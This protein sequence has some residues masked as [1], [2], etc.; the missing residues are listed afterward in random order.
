VA[1]QSTATLNGEFTPGSL[2]APFIIVNASPT[3][4]LDANAA[5]DPAVYFAFIGANPDGVDHIRLLASNVFGFEDLPNGG[6]L[7][8]ND[9]IVTA[10]L[11]A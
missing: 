5:N 7:D 9:V 10:N 8:Y 1:N 6:D 11:V 2:F 4:V 3:E